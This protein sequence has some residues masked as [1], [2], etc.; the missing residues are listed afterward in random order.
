MWL[1]Q[2]PFSKSACFHALHI[3]GGNCPRLLPG[4]DLDKEELA[5][6]H[7]RNRAF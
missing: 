6:Y 5:P 4:S 7:K 3:L 2:Y 1:D